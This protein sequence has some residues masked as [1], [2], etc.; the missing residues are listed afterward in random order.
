MQVFYLRH[1]LILKWKSVCSISIPDPVSYKDHHFS[2]Q[3]TQHFQVPVLNTEGCIHKDGEAR[4]GFF[5]L[6]N[7]ASFQ[8]S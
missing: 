7:F 3:E 8:Y 5:R 1:Q 6:I 4:K 2:K